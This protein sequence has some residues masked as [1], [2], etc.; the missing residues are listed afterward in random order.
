[1]SPDLFFSVQSSKVVV[2]V[3]IPLIPDG[4]QFIVPP[5]YKLLKQVLVYLAMLNEL[6]YPDE[7]LSSDDS[8]G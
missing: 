6:L 2:C 7:R 1:M 5:G 4:S 3:E 8:L